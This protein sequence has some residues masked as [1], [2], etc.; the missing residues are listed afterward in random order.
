VLIPATAL[1]VGATL[2]THDTKESGRV[3]GLR[4]EDRF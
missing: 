1:E 3:K 4:L 2:V